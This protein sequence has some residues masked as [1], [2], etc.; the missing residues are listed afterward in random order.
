MYSSEQ[1]ELVKMST[2]HGWLWNLTW[3]HDSQ[4]NRDKEAICFK[5]S[6]SLNKI[7]MEGTGNLVYH[8]VHN[9]YAVQ[10]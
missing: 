3:S 7:M 9:H 2:Y 1:R 10:D 8:Q 5:K 6:F 4:S